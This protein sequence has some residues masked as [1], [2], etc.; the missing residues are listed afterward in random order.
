MRRVG[1]YVTLD[2]AAATITYSP[3][4][5]VQVLAP[6]N[7]RITILGLDIGCQDDTPASVPITFEWSVQSGAQNPSGA[8][9]TPEKRDRGYSETLQGNFYKWNAMATED[10]PAVNQVFHT[11]GL[12]RQGHLPWMPAGSP[13]VV[14]GGEKVGLRYRSSE[15]SPGIK[16]TITLYCEQ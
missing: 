2:T 8:E 3:F 7:Q 13:I 4:T 10:E 16:T 5:L 12:H 15:I 6:T 11:F 9:I 14:K 1:F